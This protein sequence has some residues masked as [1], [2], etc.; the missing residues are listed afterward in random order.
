MRDW[1]GCQFNAII[2]VDVERENRGPK[3]RCRGLDVDVVVIVAV[4][5]VL[6][7]WRAAI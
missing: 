5:V 3:V 1:T 6:L 4:V 2:S 7:G